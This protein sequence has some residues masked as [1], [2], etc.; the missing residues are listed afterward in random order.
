[1]SRVTSSVFMGSM[2]AAIV[3]LNAG[4]TVQATVKTKTRFEEPGV[5]AQSTTTD[6][7]KGEPIKIQAEG[8]GVA[9]NGGLTVRVDPNAK[10][11]SA[12]AKMVA[13]AEA[14][15]KTSADASIVDAKATFKITKDGSG[16]LVMCGHGGTHGTSNAGESG[17]ND[18]TVTI[19]AGDTTNLVD[20][21]ALSGNGS[22]NVDLSAV[23]GLK[24][25]GV[26]GK[27]DITFRGPSTAAATKGAIVSIVAP[28]ADDIS[29]LV[30][31]DFSADEIILQADADKT[32]NGFS[33]V[34]LDSS[35]K[36]KRG[37]AGEGYASIKATS[38]EFAGET[39]KVS[40]GSL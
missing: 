22:V 32:T 16:W 36:G 30:A 2:V 5:S 17:C 19:P 6:E 11:I 24:R 12:T 7:W 26:N 8:V 33:D 23:G 10:T 37:N 3:A 20:L 39:G 27:G 38:Q 29:V 4:C 9:V 18:V 35:G 21:E 13:L 1:M 28:Q 15:D 25:A 31:R 40:L 34:T 14:E